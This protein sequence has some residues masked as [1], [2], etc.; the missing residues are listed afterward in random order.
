M[1]AI[2]IGLNVFFLVVL[3]LLCAFLFRQKYYK[4]EL[5]V[6]DDFIEHW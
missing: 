5:E 2:C 6:F 1:N 4:F 3:L